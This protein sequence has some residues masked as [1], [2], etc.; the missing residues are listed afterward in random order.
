M[1]RSWHG[2]PIHTQHQVYKA[3]IHIHKK[4]ITAWFKLDSHNEVSKQG[5]QEEYL[6]EI[7]YTVLHTVL[8]L[9]LPAS[10]IVSHQQ[11]FSIKRSSVIELC[12]PWKQIAWG[13]GWLT[14]IVTTTQK[15]VSGNRCS[16]SA[17]SK[18]LS[19]SQGKGHS[20]K[21]EETCKNSWLYINS[22]QGFRSSKLQYCQYFL[23]PNMVIHGTNIHNL[24]HAM[25]QC[26]YVYI[27]HH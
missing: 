17:V 10:Y 4:I 24:K 7:S 3:P 8:E 1:L 6:P 11:P 5:Y 26:K 25:Q 14:R 20:Q 12:T 23:R 13:Y 21:N 19:E 18:P 2:R 9:K 22:Q 16:K 27:M 15:T